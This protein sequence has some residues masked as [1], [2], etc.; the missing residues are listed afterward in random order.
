MQEW[1]M[2]APSSSCNNHIHIR[3][4]SV[5]HIYTC[6]CAH[7]HTNAGF[8][9]CM[10]LPVT[11]AIIYTYTCAHTHTN[12]G[13]LLCMI[14]PVTAAIIYTS[15]HTF[16]YLCVHIYIYIYIYIYTYIHTYIHMCVYIHKCRVS[17]MHD[18]TSSCSNHI[19]ILT[20]CVQHGTDQR[21]AR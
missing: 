12:A 19:R 18:P 20:T 7:T 9:L 5:P 1:A 13:F 10:I 3:A 17:T 8:L 21:S 6:T 11:A 14:L 16:V 15:S 4:T 2:H